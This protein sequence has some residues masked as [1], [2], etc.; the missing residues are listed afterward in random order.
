MLFFLVVK[1]MNTLIQRMR[2]QPPLDPTTRKCPY[3]LSDIPIAAT[4]C[5]F[6][7]Q[8]VPV[9]SQTANVPA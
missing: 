3:C 6:C 9:V 8:E 2:R 4:R 5:A 1:P 7:T